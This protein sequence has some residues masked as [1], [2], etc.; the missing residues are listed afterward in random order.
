MKYIKKYE[1][2]KPE[3]EKGDYVAVRLIDN[4]AA[5]ARELEKHIGII[6]GETLSNVKH[7]NVKF[8]TTLWWINRNEIIDW[9]KNK[10]DLAHY[11]TSN[12]FN[13]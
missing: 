13:L 1:D 12:K 3:P 4:P 6:D 9:S 5:I 11:I 7:Y 10:E 8:G 2:V